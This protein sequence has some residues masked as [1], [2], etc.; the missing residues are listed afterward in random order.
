MILE[1]LRRSALV[2][3]KIKMNAKELA[4]KFNAKVG[5]AAVE[6]EGQSGLATEHIQKC[7]EDIEHCKRAL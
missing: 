6:R 2:H 3:G 5:A 7:R 1:T 4:D